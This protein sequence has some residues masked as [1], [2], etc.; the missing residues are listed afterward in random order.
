MEDAQRQGAEERRAA[1][2]V[3]AVLALERGGVASRV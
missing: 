1:A 3:V 2:E